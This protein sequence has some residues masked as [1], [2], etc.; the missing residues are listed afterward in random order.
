M[1]L[2]DFPVKILAQENNVGGRSGGIANWFLLVI[3]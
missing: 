1:R 3:I 2:E